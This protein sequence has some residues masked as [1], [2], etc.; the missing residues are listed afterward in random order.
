MAVANN[1]SLRWKAG[2]TVGWAHDLTKYQV[3][4]HIHH[5]NFSSEFRRH[6]LSSTKF[7][8]KVGKST[9]GVQNVLRWREAYLE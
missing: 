2:E 3:K 9:E 8:H 6:E 5:D 7:E 1:R 4:E